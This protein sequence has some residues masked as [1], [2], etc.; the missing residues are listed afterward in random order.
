MVVLCLEC[1]LRY[2]PETKLERPMDGQLLFP[3]CPEARSPTPTGNAWMFL[4]MHYP[5]LV[6][7]TYY[8]HDKIFYRNLDESVAHLRRHATNL[9]KAS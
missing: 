1:P 8:D 5:L 2:P 3:S 4:W 6:A 9:P 7:G